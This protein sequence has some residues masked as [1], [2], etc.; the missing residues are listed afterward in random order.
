VT[1]SIHSKLPIALTPKIKSATVTLVIAVTQNPDI[2][3]WDRGLRDLARIFTSHL[4]N[5][6]SAELFRAHYPV[7]ME[8]VIDHRTLGS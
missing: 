7:T 3:S 2:S 6:V 8:S 5:I 4:L 1:N